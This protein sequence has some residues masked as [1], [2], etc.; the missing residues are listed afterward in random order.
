MIR[1][2]CILFMCL[3]RSLTL[4]TAST[5]GT[6][7]GPTTTQ[8]PL[9][10]ATL[11][12]KETEFNK[13]SM[14]VILSFVGLVIVLFAVSFGVSYALFDVITCYDWS[15]YPHNNPT[16]LSLSEIILFFICFLF[17]TKCWH[18]PNNP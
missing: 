5:A 18:I 12:P 2:K 17:S 7:I 13:F 8:I 14:I 3:I 15:F 9:R 1:F 4:P 16:F 10:N 11:L 6:T